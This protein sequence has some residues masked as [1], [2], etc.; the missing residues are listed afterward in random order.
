[1]NG[2]LPG[3]LKERCET[4][5][6]FDRWDRPGWLQSVADVFR[7]YVWSLSPRQSDLNDA[8]LRAISLG[9]VGLMSFR[10]TMGIRI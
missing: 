4:K 7:A 1:M 3:N 5:V 6:M 9:I 10:S 8:G 2:C